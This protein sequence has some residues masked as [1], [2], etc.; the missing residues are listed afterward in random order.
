MATTSTTWPA[1]VLQ[2]LRDLPRQAEPMD[3]LR[4]AVSAWG[5]ATIKGKPTI[6]Q[7]I[8]LTAHF[9]VFLAAFHRLRNGLEPLESLPELDYA[10][11]YLYLLTG[12]VPRDEHVKALD[13]YLVLLADHGM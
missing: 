5:A 4:T 13:A 11:N 1:P 10:A 12:Q 3:A 9:P 8:A 2:V 7:A 6:D